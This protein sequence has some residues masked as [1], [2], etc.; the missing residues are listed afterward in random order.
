MNDDNTLTTQCPKCES[1][2]RV[3]PQHL[4]AAQGWLQCGVCGKVFHTSPA[5]PSTA[6]LPE[7][8]E[9]ETA[10]P[11]PAPVEEGADAESAIALAA[12]SAQ[13]EPLAT[14]TPQT[15]VPVRAE[16]QPPT[17]AADTETSG[18]P[19]L[20]G[21]AQRMTEQAPE[22]PFGPK[23]ESIILVDPDIPAGELGPLPTFEPEGATAPTPK[24]QPSLAA[25]GGAASA[26]WTPRQLPEHEVRGRKERSWMWVV[27][28]LLLTTA[29]GA[30]L[31][32]FLR[33]DLAVRYPQSRPY[34]AR[35][36]SALDCRLSLPRDT[37]QVLILGSDLQTESQGNL[38]L[39]VTL[40][41]RADHAMAW[42]VL[43]LTLNDIKDQP[44]GRR[45]FAPS[46]YLPSPE[47]EAAGIQPLSEV[48][49]TLKLQ[50]K[51][52]KAAGYRLQMFY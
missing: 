15:E 7:V 44:L 29:L 24:A 3:Q 11:G 35:L 28:A 22:A 50:T 8:K 21:L 37:K 20:T 27:A 52:I 41:N 10:A 9:A 48:P 17:G 23:L 39:A 46:E 19:T 49:L 43:E 30:Q 2:F 42:P 5:V 45:V 36:C 34:L 4:A 1:V 47:M 31:I 16:E 32:Y 40:A 26:S 13:A 51:E 6:P 25:Q 33:D 12:P 38:A 18:P 14:T